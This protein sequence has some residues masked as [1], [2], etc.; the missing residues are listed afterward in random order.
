[1]KINKYLNITKRIELL[2]AIRN[3]PSKFKYK[4]EK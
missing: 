3:T 4:K 1:M 2:N